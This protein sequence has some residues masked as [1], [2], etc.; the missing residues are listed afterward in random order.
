MGRVKSITVA[1]D[2]SGLGAIL[3]AALTGAAAFHADS[4]LNTLRQVIEDSPSSPRSSRPEVDRNLENICLK[5]LEKRPASRYASARHLTDDLERYLNGEAVLARPVGSLERAGRWCRRHPL[6]ASLV[7]A[8]MAVV[9]TAFIAVWWQWKEAIAQQHLAETNAVKFEAQRDRAIAATTQ[10]E[11]NAAET[12][13]QRSLAETHLAAAESRFA[14]AQA[15]IQELIRLGVELVRQ[16]NME[17]RGRQALEKASQFR[18]ALLEE[19]MD[20]PEA[21]WV[22][23]STF[24]TLAWTLLEHGDF[25]DAELTYG[26]ALK[27]LMDLHDQ[28]P[29]SRRYLQLMRRVCLERGVAMKRCT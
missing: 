2:V 9:T 12:Q 27:I 16:P 13:Y 22:T 26:Q 14:K 11:A 24:H 15:P 6:S 17:A 21:R 1:A 4:D 5:C 10:A 8:L 20:D 18:Q 25:T 7:A 29:D 28:D 3:Y 23:A 19:K